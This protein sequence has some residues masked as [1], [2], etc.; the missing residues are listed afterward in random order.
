MLLTAFAAIILLSPGAMGDFLDEDPDLDGYSGQFSL[1]GE[2]LLTTREEYENGTDPFDRDSDNDGM[3]DGWEIRWD[4]DPNDPS[5]A[6][7]DSDGDGVSNIDEFYDDTNPRDIDL[8]QDGMPDVWEEINGLDPTNASDALE[9]PDGDG[10]TNYQEFLNNTLPF[11]EDTDGDGMWDGWEVLNGL[12]PTNPLDG[13]IDSDH[14]GVSNVGEFHNSTDPW[15]P[16]DDYGNAGGGNGGSGIPT[17][18]GVPPDTGRTD[19]EVTLINVFDPPLGSLKR[20]QVLDA[21]GSN[22]LIYLKNT[23][24]TPLPVS[25]GDYGFIYYGALNVSLVEGVYFRLPNPAPDSVLLDYYFEERDFGETP[26]LF[27]KDPADNY[28]VLAPYD[29]DPDNTTIYTDTLYFTFGTDGSYFSLDI[30]QS[31][32]T[33][34]VPGWLLPD[35]TSTIRESVDWFLD[36]ADDDGVRALDGE[37]GLSIIVTNLTSYFS[38]FTAGDGDVPDPVGDQDIYQAIAINKVGACRHRSFA[39]FV[40]ANA[41]GVPTRYVANEVHCFV[42]VYVPDGPYSDSNW[43]RIDLG[44]T[45]SMDPGDPRP[46][47]PPGSNETVI[48]LGP[49]PGV[50]Y[51]GVPFQITG[52]I[53][54]LNGT[55]LPFYPYIVLSD[56]LQVG[57]GSSDSA[58]NISLPITLVDIRLG[59]HNLTLMTRPYHLYLT[60]SSDNRSYELFTHVHLNPAWPLT[61]GSPGSFTMG[62]GMTIFVAGYLSSV[63][64]T[65]LRN[66]SVNLTWD[67]SPGDLFT[68][69][70]Q[71]E[72]NLSIPVNAS[73]S[74]GSHVLA[75]RF[76]GYGYYL[77]SNETITVN[78][79][80]V[81]VL[82]SAKVEPPSQDASANVTITGRVTDS[83]GD[84]VSRRGNLL[85]IL[86]GLVLVNS[87][88]SDHTDPGGKDFNV[89]VT[90]PST[91]SRGDYVLYMAFVPDQGESLPAATVNLDLHVDK[92]TTLIYLFPGIIEIGERYSINGTLFTGSGIPVPGDV[93]LY[94]D[95]DFLTTVTVDGNGDFLYQNI[96]R[97]PPGPVEITALYNGSD[98]FI[99]SSATVNYSV[100]SDTRFYLPFIEPDQGPITRNQTLTFH[101]QLLDDNSVN[102][103]DMTIYLYVT[104]S[105]GKEWLANSTTT[106]SSGFT[107]R[108]NLSRD[109][110]PGPLDF[111]LLF[112]ETG[113]YR[114]SSQDLHFT[115]HADTFIELINIT[116]PVLAGTNLTFNGRFYDDMG[117]P[118]ELPL[119]ITFLGT[120]YI[121]ILENGTIRWELPIPITQA[122]G[123]YELLVSFQKLNNYE[124][125]SLRMDITIYHLSNLTVIPVNLTR[126]TYGIF[127]GS[128]RDE[129]GNGIPN[130]TLD[131]YLR[132]GYL[133]SIMTDDKGNYLVSHL[134]ED[135]LAL[136]PAVV[137][138]LFNGSVY[139]S[140]NRANFS[141]NVFA[142]THIDLIEL[143][144]ATRDLL[145]F[146]GS[147]LDNLNTPQPSRNVTLTFNGEEVNVT[148][149]DNGSFIH[150]YHG[151]MTLGFYTLTSRFAG[152]GFY[153]RSENV[154]TIHVVSPLN[155]TITY[156]NDPVA[157][158]GFIVTG[159]IRDDQGSPVS[160]ELNITLASARNITWK[161]PAAINGL[162]NTTW[163][164]EPGMVPGWYTLYINNS[165]P[166]PNTHYLASSISTQL[167]LR[168]ATSI[169][170]VVPAAIRGEDVIITGTLF[171]VANHS[172]PFAE[173]RLTFD[174]QILLELTDGDGNFTFTLDI[175]PDSDPGPHL[176][177]VEYSGNA[178]L[179]PANAQRTMWVLVPTT[180]LLEP[181]RTHVSGIDITGRVVDNLGEPAVGDV[182]IYFDEKYV[183]HT[184]ADASGFLLPMFPQKRIGIFEVRAEYNEY[185]YYLPSN[186]T[187]NYTLFTYILFRTNITSPISDTMPEEFGLENPVLAGEYFNLTLN[188]TTDIGIDPPALNMMFWFEE[189][190]NLTNMSDSRTMFYVSKVLFPQEAHQLLI[191]DLVKDPFF[192]LDP[193]PTEITINV[194]QPTRIIIT[195]EQDAGILT[196]TGSVRD[197]YAGG[198]PVE[199]GEI[200]A[201]QADS[202]LGLTLNNGVFVYIAN[203]S[204]R[205]GPENYSFV[206]PINEYYLGSEKNLTIYI[207]ARTEL[208]IDV[209]ESAYFGEEF[210]GTVTLTYPNGDPIPKAVLF[211]TLGD[212]EITASTNNDGKYNFRQIM[213]T[214][215]SIVITVEFV[216]NEYFYGNTTSKE[217]KIGKKGDPAFTLSDFFTTRA[218][219]TYIIL[220]GIGLYVWRRKQFNY[221]MSLMHDTA[222]R[223]DA[224][225]SPKSVVIIAYNLMCRHL[226]RFNLIR[227]D[228]ETV[229][230]FKGTTQKKMRLSEDGIGDLTNMMEYADYSHLDT[231]EGHKEHAVRSLRN[232]ERELAGL[233]IPRRGRK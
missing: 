61:A 185:T 230:E 222:L 49:V 150:H 171:D 11:D 167:F 55:P 210:K 6:D 218:F 219:I 5:D 166:Y 196:I 67:G 98:M 86:H 190:Q 231:S 51:M 137:D 154:M 217:V 135:D 72:Y 149:D 122:S 188:I 44:G 133:R 15:D 42:E 179:L 158:Q 223:L 29:D 23:T 69:T 112:R 108:Y 91:L 142:N 161:Y 28:Y 63:N 101:G 8:D 212:E 145:I 147:L 143:A 25:G 104:D 128:I 93:A 65:L 214:N 71:G 152:D 53:S 153:H 193:D 173:L 172:I 58:G 79:T 14:G 73:E 16:T 195:Q 39:F 38:S 134:L 32:T 182:D 170:L 103:E 59:P 82:H 151:N 78:V 200:N 21:L 9:D 129:L 50:V 35:I 34:D 40:T 60:N 100:F 106:D 175:P 125:T 224:G 114:G 22:Y 7:I 164:L 162:F 46:P 169:E 10:L 229:S 178:T 225:E 77:S 3:W 57:S 13:A 201:S 155:I 52:N 19:T 163:T 174:D 206:Y 227:R 90:I 97:H 213:S 33:A 88:L 139:Y 107:F 74:L 184:F 94:W 54:T 159:T 165:N 199:N 209:Q 191:S 119:T 24:T 186:A 105:L 226:R 233:G 70:D 124:G 2:E 116:N 216:G 183:G 232:V 117:H 148:T 126:G 160:A 123:D 4:F 31:L 62:R 110:L 75:V 189:D 99:S 83:S 118:L 26:L 187:T 181:K 192:E 141:T 89:T 211:L 45:G 168:R 84:N 156:M 180:V 1:P 202:P 215:H 109:Y 144:Y 121:P 197:S 205:W 20:W 198:R 221:L 64:G 131:I 81:T 30:P 37:T 157:G 18:D 146:R 95:G 17:G 96:T 36:N 85:I 48:R 127:S 203:V 92:I 12:N 87:S 194:V 177:T 204:D 76:T 228:H 132:G 138:I 102:V 27:F 113:Y 220:G 207:K 47:E 120:Q 68:T 140:Q 41:L 130:L 136:G 66:E 111:E 56:G 208:T 80:T 176:I 43:H 115:V